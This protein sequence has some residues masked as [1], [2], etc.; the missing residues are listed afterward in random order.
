VAPAN[1]FD[2]TFLELCGALNDISYFALRGIGDLPHN[3]WN[4]LVLSLG[5]RDWALA[6]GTFT[7]HIGLAELL[8]VKNRAIMVPFIAAS[9]ILM[10]SLVNVLMFIWVERKLLARF[11]DRRG[12]MVSGPFGLLQNVW[13]GMKLLTKENAHPAKAD[14]L[15][16]FLC[17]V[18]LV[19]S[20]FAAIAAIPLSP[21]A[22]IAS[23]DLD[24]L[25]VLMLFAFSPYAV[26]LGGWA[27][28]NKFSLIGG[29]RS[30][31]QM[32]AG[33]VPFFLSVGGVVL[34]VGSFRFA[35]IVAW[36]DTHGWLAFSQP[37]GFVLFTV[38]VLIELERIP[39]DLPEAESELVEG[40]TTEYSG[41]RWGML[42]LGGYLRGY[43]GCAMIVLMFLGGASMPS[44]R[45]GDIPVFTPHIL[46]P[47]V[48]FLGK[49]YLVFAAF[50]WL[51]ASYPRLRTDQ[52]L[53]AG[54]KRLLP[55]TLV[56]IL[57]AGAVVD[58][59]HPGEVI[60]TPLGPMLHETYVAWAAGLF[61][62][63]AI[64][65]AY[66][67][68]F[69]P[70]VL[71]PLTVTARMLIS[72]SELFGGR[73]FT[74]LYPYERLEVPEAGRWLHGLSDEKCISCARCCRICPDNCLNMVDTQHGQHPDPRF[75]TRPALD[76]SHC[77]FCGLCVEVCPTGALTMGPNYELAGFSRDELYW[78]QDELMGYV[79]HGMQENPAKGEI[80]VKD[81]IDKLI[82]PLITPVLKFLSPHNYERAKGTHTDAYEVPS[83][84]SGLAG[85]V[86]DAHE[87]GLLIDGM[88]TRSKKAVKMLLD[89]MKKKRQGPA[90]FSAWDYRH[91]RKHE[92]KGSGFGETPPEEEGEV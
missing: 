3:V 50:V 67:M 31:A 60:D 89:D 27:S 14:M 46:P 57:I 91:T 48:I 90:D 66:A 83:L 8:F 35:D 49:A 79:D 15:A 64:V 73:P 36:Q 84:V 44:Y 33:E 37:L 75:T 52:L 18:I 72:S 21:K 42:W 82:F 28:Y 41:L 65:G 86:K 19:G 17:P 63:L 24:L 54:W 76:A 1:P 40:W 2:W 53:S 51:R 62:F 12:P 92:P 39:F 38:G 22:A 7:F 11:M 74:V 6:P 69:T 32:L 59:S 25:Y 81:W 78:S 23:I 70:R 56:N 68:H 71:Q 61:T 30:A 10:F 55:L 77:M 4:V 43:V 45:V 80:E 5:M 26:F 13:D 20:A 29:M 88:S 87:L 16:F 85:E 34:V 9:L 58:L 47:V